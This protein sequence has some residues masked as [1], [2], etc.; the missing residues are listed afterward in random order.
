MANNITPAEFEAAIRDRMGNDPLGFLLH[1]VVEEYTPEELAMDET[2]RFVVLVARNRLIELGRED[3]CSA[4]GR[5]A[6]R[7][8]RIL[9]GRYWRF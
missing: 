4:I 9:L 8:P 1:N 7:N 5:R 6:S 2:V 3:G